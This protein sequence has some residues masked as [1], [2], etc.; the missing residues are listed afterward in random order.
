MKL[1]HK[2]R[3]IFAYRTTIKLVKQN[4][5]QLSTESLALARLALAS[6]QL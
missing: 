1:F 6:N 2:I 5:I 4:L 3:Y